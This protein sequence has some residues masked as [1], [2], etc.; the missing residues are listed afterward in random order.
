LSSG[1]S[2]LGGAK[3]SDFVFAVGT[4]VRLRLLDGLASPNPAN[5]APVATAPPTISEIACF[6]LIT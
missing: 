1:E 3:P 4:F 6:L 5:T 2:L